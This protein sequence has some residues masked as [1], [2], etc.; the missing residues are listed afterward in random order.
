MTSDRNAAPAPA[1]HGLLAIMAAAT[2]ALAA[3]PAALAASPRGV[4]P[5]A[6]IG[7]ADDEAGRIAAIGASGGSVLTT[8]SPRITVV[9]PDNT[10]FAG[11]MRDQGYWIILDAEAV[12]GCLPPGTGKRKPT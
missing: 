11:R 4:R 12:P 10:G 7:I 5:V 2:L 8:V 9:V 6:V 3:V 1:S